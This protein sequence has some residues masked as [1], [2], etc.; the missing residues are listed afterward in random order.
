MS[1]SETPVSKSNTEVANTKPASKP[2]ISILKALGFTVI[3]M[4]ATYILGIATGVLQSTIEHLFPGWLSTSLPALLSNIAILSVAVS[5]AT[6]FGVADSARRLLS[7]SNDRISNLEKKVAAEPEK[8][9]F[10]WELAQVKLET[11]FDRNLSQVRLIF[12]VAVLVMLVGFGFVLWGVLLSFYNPSSV[13]TAY[14]AALSGVVT[15]FIGVTFMVVY[16]SAMAQ[17]NQFMA[18]LERINTVGMA[19]QILDAMPDERSELKNS[20]RSQVVNL[21]LQ[22]NDRRK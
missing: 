6:V 15:Q 22:S 3:G 8:T 9:K 13:K 1:N 16:R 20:T 21:L 17:A 12:L 18:V 4:L 19:V 11:Y 5:G 14:V 7:R 2:K 10:A